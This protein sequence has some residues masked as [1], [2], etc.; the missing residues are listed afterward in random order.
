MNELKA[1]IIIFFSTLN[2]KQRRLYAGLE[3]LKLGKS[4]DKIISDLLGVNIKT[5]NK[6]KH[7]LLN[8]SVN[9]DTIRTKGGGRK[10]K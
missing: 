8:N 10:K 4:G 9:V 1:G 6:G 2:E 3:S 7:E 5:V